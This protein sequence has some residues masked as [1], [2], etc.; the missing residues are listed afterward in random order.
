MGDGSEI[1]YNVFS[2]IDILFS[3]MMLLL[4]PGLLRYLRRQPQRLPLKLFRQL[5]RSQFQQQHLQNRRLKHLCRRRRQFRLHICPN[6][7]TNPNIPHLP[8]RHLANRPPDDQ[9]WAVFIYIRFKRLKP[10]A[11]E[12]C[13]KITNSVN[14]IISFPHTCVGYVIVKNCRLE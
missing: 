5:A 3:R 14:V 10:N 11:Q 4:P 13:A 2:H 9:M 12:K 8:P 1:K 6:T 7:T